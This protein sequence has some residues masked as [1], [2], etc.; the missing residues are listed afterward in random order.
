MV[1]GGFG[2]E[3]AVDAIPEVAEHLRSHPY[4][5]LHELFAQPAPSWWDRCVQL[6]EQVRGSL[7]QLHTALTGGRAPPAEEQWSEGAKDQ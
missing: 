3:Q 2:R 1:V 4:T 7:S 6:L 5:D